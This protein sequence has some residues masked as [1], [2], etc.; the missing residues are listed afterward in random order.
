[1]LCDRCK[2]NQATSYI[3]TTINGVT[4]E[5]H[6]CSACAAKEGVNLSNFAQNINPFSFFKAEQP[7]QPAAKR[8]PLCG[9]SFEELQEIGKVGCPQCYETFREELKPT[10]K[11][12]HGAERHQGRIQGVDARREKLTEL[13]A[14]LTDCIKT[15]DYEQAAVL[16]D[17]IKELEDESCD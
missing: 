16:R 1:M 12:L 3:K 8:C 11:S 10:L 17:Q 6:L 7:E 4:K 9:R 13:K 2:Q 5:E 15:Q 14:Q